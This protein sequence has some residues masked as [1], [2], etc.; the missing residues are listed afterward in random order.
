MCL[1]SPLFFYIAILQGFPPAFC[2][3][4]MKTL[5]ESRVF[6]HNLAESKGFELCSRCFYTSLLALD[7]RPQTIDTLRFI[8]SISFYLYTNICSKG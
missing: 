5:E 7:E 4:M 3:L 6:I 2:S 1:A 8:R